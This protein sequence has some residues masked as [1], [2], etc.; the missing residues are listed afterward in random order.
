MADYEQVVK[1]VREVRDGFSKIT[2]N[3]EGKS[4]EPSRKKYSW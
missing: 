4:E 3:K 2:A 1:D